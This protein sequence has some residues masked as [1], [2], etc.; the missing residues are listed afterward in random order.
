MPN[1]IG[2]GVEERER[3]TK[4]LEKRTCCT[5]DTQDEMAG[6]RLDIVRFGRQLLKSRS[7]SSW[8][9]FGCYTR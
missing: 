9:L 6:F 2:K 1:L 5:L 8:W 3:R 4:V 7:L